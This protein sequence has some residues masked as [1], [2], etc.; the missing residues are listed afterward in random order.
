MKFKKHHRVTAGTHKGHNTK[1]DLAFADRP[2]TTAS[3]ARARA[4][5]WAQVHAIVISPFTG[6]P[7]SNAADRY[8]KGIE[9]V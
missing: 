4:A 7:L 6:K 3:I 5:Y 2:D 1:M 9:Y 8:R